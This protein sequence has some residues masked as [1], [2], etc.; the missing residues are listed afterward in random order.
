[1][2]SAVTCASVA[3]GIML[4][5][6]LTNSLR[7]AE[8]RVMPLVQL[9]KLSGGALLNLL[10]CALYTWWSRP[11]SSAAPRVLVV[12][13][14]AVGSV[15]GF[16]LARGGARV[17]FLV[18]EDRAESL[19]GLRL[20][21]LGLCTCSKGSAAM[22]KQVEWVGFD[23]MTNVRDCCGP[24][25]LRADPPN[26]T[27]K[28]F[29][30]V[31][32]A[33]SAAAARAA[34]PVLKQLVES[35]ERDCAVVRVVSE[36]GEDDFFHNTLSVHHTQLIDLGIGF[37]SYASPL[38]NRA[39]RYGV[40]E[41]EAAAFTYSI[42]SSMLLSSSANGAGGHPMTRRLAECFNSGE[43]PCSCVPSVGAALAVPSA[44]LL[45]LVTNL[46][47]ADW[48][49]ASIKHDPERQ[50]LL[51]RSLGEA[52][53]IATSS[54]EG[55]RQQYAEGYCGCRTRLSRVLLTSGCVLRL[56]LWVATCTHCTSLTSNAILPFDLELFLT[57]H[58]SKLGVVTILQYSSASSSLPAAARL[59][60]LDSDRIG[61]NSPPPKVSAAGLPRHPRVQQKTADEVVCMPETTSVCSVCSAQAAQT[62]L[63]LEAYITTAQERKLPAEA[64]RELAA[65]LPKLPKPRGATG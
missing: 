52:V 29:D 16:H 25:R 39:G 64:L 49:F 21:R 45:G 46:E 9:V 65:L 14:G 7:P 34:S 55:Q 5:T 41:E 8:Q 2:Y 32:L 40:G 44:A 27:P 36:L 28:P 37:M 60:G 35:L 18:R 23:L 57:Q 56:A 24:V 42:T 38:E 13:C 22:I 10:V 50:A 11:K 58:F 54:T 26:Q 33:V 43:L 59:P 51:S 12:G 20:E 6:V 19:L 4:L 63:F 62:R 15:V 48:A 3:L 17:A 53:A 31:I 47:H 30:T 1:M 61:S